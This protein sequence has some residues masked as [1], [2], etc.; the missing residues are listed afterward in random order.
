M[1]QIPTALTNCQSFLQEDT[2]VLQKGE[3]LQRT[4]LDA[5][6]PSPHSGDKEATERDSKLHY[7]TSPMQEK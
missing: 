2:A 3:E 6:A 1:N 4:A 5:T 7:N